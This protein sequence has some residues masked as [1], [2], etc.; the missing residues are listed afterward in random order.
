MQND[1][2]ITE[3]LKLIDLINFFYSHYKT[4]NFKPLW[5]VFD[6]LK[7]QVKEIE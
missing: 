5:E 4:I 6:K 3:K 1:I 2:N 7:E